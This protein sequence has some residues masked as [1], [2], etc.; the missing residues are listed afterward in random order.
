MQ[1]EVSLHIPQGEDW[2]DNYNHDILDESWEEDSMVTCGDINNFP[3][4][5]MLLKFLD[6]RAPLPSKY[7]ETH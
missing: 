1:N 7:R 5:S 4:Q 6:T 2:K 3:F